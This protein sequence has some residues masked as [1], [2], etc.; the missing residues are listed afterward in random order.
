MGR[1]CTYTAWAAHPSLL[2]VLHGSQADRSSVSLPYLSCSMSR[3]LQRPSPVLGTEV[4]LTAKSHL[5]LHLKIELENFHLHKN[6]P[7]RRGNRYQFVSNYHGAL[8][9][10]ACYLSAWKCVVAQLCTRGCAI[11][12]GIKKDESASPCFKE[13]SRQRYREQMDGH[14]MGGGVGTA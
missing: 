7:S 10:S 1:K 6:L 14:Q 3:S 5:S 8:P 12:R 11:L 13:F 2:R 9:P 4:L